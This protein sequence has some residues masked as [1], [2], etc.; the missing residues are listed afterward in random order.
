MI[1]AKNI[2]KI[3][4]RI[5]K[6]CCKTG[7][8]RSDITLMAVTKFVPVNKI[9]EAYKSG[10][11]CFGE[12]RVKEAAEKLEVFMKEHND[13]RFHLIG[14]LQRNKAKQAALF[15]DCIQSVDRDEL[16]LDLKKYS[17]LRSSPLEIL[18]EL[19]TGEESKSGYR[20]LS[21]LLKAAELAVKSEKLKPA[22]LMTMAPY[23]TDADLIRSSFRQLAAAQKELEKYFPDEN[24]TCLSMGMSNDYEIAID[25]GSTLLRIGSAIFKE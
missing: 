9:E 25:E 10:I 14:S 16:L 17:L 15:F 13:T 6:A 5:Q 20:D 4:E 12:S 11:N 21:D 23:T 24:W 8:K 1:I 7:R 3:E 19:H 22:G 2:A 18:L